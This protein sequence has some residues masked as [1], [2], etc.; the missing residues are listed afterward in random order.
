MSVKLYIGNALDKLR[1][2]M[3][4]SIDCCITSPPYWGLRDYGT[5]QWEG[6]NPNCQH[7]IF[8]NYHDPTRRTERQTRNRSLN[9]CVKCGAFRVDAP[10]GMEPTPQEHIAALVEVFREVRR[11]LKPCGTCWINY[12]DMYASSVNGRAAVDVVKDNR[13]FRDKP[14]STVGNG[15][16]PKDLIMMS[17]MLA[18][19]L[20]ADGWY[21]RNE[22]IWHKPNAMPESVKDRCAVC[23]EK[24]FLLTKFPRYYF[25]AAAVKEP[26]AALAGA[27][28]QHANAL[29]FER[30]V[31]EPERP[32][33][34]DK[35]HRPGKGNNKSFRGGGV[36]TN[37]RA[38][39]N[40]TENAKKT[41]GNKPGESKLRLRRTVWTVATKGFKEAHFATF[42]PELIRPCILAGCPAGGIVLDPFGGAGT[43]ALVAEREQR[44]PILIELNPEY[45]KLI[46]QRLKDDGGLF[47]G[48][49]N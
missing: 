21:L 42:P 31:N 10:I 35:R 27:R 38:F 11:V 25:N 29:S 33:H 7:T 49:D 1:E 46:Y 44:N 3:D 12:A 19:A 15:F 2:L 14:F 9:R 32:G 16:K 37:N 13:T 24:I 28:K 45:G 4:N 8:E 26:I 5:A 20:Q 43:T 23:H 6:G 22:I 41:V 40:S 36:Y 17:A 48:M 30:F 47:A 18:L 34:N 39:D